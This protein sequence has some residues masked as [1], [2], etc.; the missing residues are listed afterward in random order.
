MPNGHKG[1]VVSIDAKLAAIRAA[2]REKALFDVLMGFRDDL[3]SPDA[4]EAHAV[5]RELRK[6]FDLDP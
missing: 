6:A 5:L 4:D 3:F 2:W 1:R